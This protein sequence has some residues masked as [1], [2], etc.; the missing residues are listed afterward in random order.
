MAAALVEG[1]EFHQD[2]KG[3]W[4]PVYTNDSVPKAKGILHDVA[5]A[6]RFRSIESY[7]RRSGSHPEDVKARITALKTTNDNTEATK[8]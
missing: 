6:L 4:S 3:Y 8:E 5:K 1:I 7:L 2:S